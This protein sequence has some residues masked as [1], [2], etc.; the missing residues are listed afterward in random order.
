[1]AMLDAELKVQ[2]LLADAQK[3][4]ETL[5]E[6][7]KEVSELRD[8]VKQLEKEVGSR[9]RIGDLPQRPTQGPND[10]H[11]GK[12]SSASGFQ[13]EPLGFVPEL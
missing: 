8:R 10:D 9:R 5:L 4:K 1:M 12:S 2:E 13:K 6:R 7:D 3:H 11:K